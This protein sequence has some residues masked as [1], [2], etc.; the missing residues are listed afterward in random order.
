MI[1]LFYT[2]R[3][4]ISDT[5]SA[6]KKIL[7]KYY[8]IERAVILRNEH[9]KPFLQDGNLFFSVSHTKKLFF[10][11]VAPFP[12]GL[13]TE[14]KN[15]K[16]EFLSIAKKYPFF[17]PLP[18]T[19]EEFLKAW[20]GFESALKYLGG[21]IALD[22]KKI[23]KDDCRFHFSQLEVDGHFLCVCSDVPSALRLTSF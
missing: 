15:R 6:L 17:T 22:G 4:K 3:E 10:V 14:L 8:G 12:V 20:T 21:S 16:V 13:D 9:G 19:A 7:S 1:D 2:S 18:T 5:E 23:K 11:A